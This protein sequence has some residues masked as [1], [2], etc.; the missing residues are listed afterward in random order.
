[1]TQQMTTCSDPSQ[2]HGDAFMGI[3]TV[4]ALATPFFLL[5]PQSSE[6][7]FTSLVF[8]GGGGLLLVC[9]VPALI[10]EWRV[11]SRMRTEAR[12]RGE[13]LISHSMGSIMGHW[14]RGRCAEAK[15]FFVAYASVV[16]LLVGDHFSGSTF[17]ISDFEN[18]NA[19]LLTWK[20]WGLQK[21]WQKLYFVKSEGVW[22][23]A[24][25]GERVFS[26]E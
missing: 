3:V 6:E 17:V 19:K 11:R 20:Y 24:R 2:P 4:I 25:D 26:D 21:E 23:F 7:N 15:M 9:L 13:A 8:V 12:R 16:A 5:S 18:G 22:K 14:W 1:M 10:S